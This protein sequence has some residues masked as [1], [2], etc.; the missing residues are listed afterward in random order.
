MS[1][2]RSAARRARLALQPLEA[3]DTP[4]GNVLAL[5]TPL[6]D[7]V[8]QGDANP[9]GNQLFVKEVGTGQ[10]SVSGANGTTVNGQPVVSLSGVTRDVKATFLDG[11]DEFNFNVSVGAPTTKLRHLIVSLGG[12][13]DFA[14]IRNTFAR[15]VTVRQSATDT[16]DDDIALSA[17][18]TYPGA[19][20]GNVKIANGWGLDA[21]KVFGGIGGNLTV[22][23]L[24]GGDGTELDGDIQIGGSVAI[25]DT[26]GPTGNTVNVGG[27]IGQDLRIVNSGDA[28]S[29]VTVL[30][31]DIGRSLF[32][33]NG[34]TTPVTS[35]ATVKQTT[36]GRDVVI[37]GGAGKDHATFDTATV[38]RT[39]T[40]L[41][42]AGADSV[43]FVNAAEVHG[44]V[45]VDDS[46]STTFTDSAVHGSVS[47]TGGADADYVIVHHSSVGRN[48]TFRGRGGDDGIS[49]ENHSTILGTA[50]FVGGPGFDV[51]Q[52]SL[53][54]NALGALNIN[55]GAGGSKTILDAVKVH[56][57]TAVL[58]GSGA[59]EFRTDSGL[60]TETFGGNLA[61]LLGGGD[62]LVTLAGNDQDRTVVGG[63]LTVATG[64]G[65][66]TLFTRWVNVL[67]RTTAGLGDGT[68]AF[69]CDDCAYHGAFAL[70]VG[71]G[72][73]FVVIETMSPAVVAVPTEFC[74]GFTLNVGTPGPNQVT[75]AKDSLPTSFV[76][77]YG[78]IAGNFRSVGSLS[79]APTHAHHVGY[80]TF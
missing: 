20:R 52:T 18:G 5:I 57:N 64:T 78:P 65:A 79:I 27:N 32:I 35:Q 77:V 33:T 69:I 9:Q 1:Y 63:N 71:E 38:G 13:A 49:V 62:N 14:D 8:I 54:G 29:L 76:D 12:G 41:G 15:N 67:G 36:V 21:T 59:D 74:G 19:I 45:F 42:R 48:L 40:V 70:S 16:G 51:F 66:D 7:L 28:L 55:H 72:S 30:E 39:V 47:M 46:E 22:A 25:T 24:G 50:T 31:A 73:D 6:G 10:F 37:A 34:S 53:A 44:S 26:A 60:E 80:A 23:N 4:A 68:D 3:R 75:I 56:G 17:G 58:A 43:E 61:L 11:P 2:F